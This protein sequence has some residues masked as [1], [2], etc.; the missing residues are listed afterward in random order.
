MLHEQ[1]KEQ[2][3][4]AG[5]STNHHRAEGVRGLAAVLCICK[6]RSAFAYRIHV[7]REHCLNKILNSYS[8]PLTPEQISEGIA[9]AQANALRLLDDARLLLE[10]GRLA[11]AAALA[12]L[13]MEERGKTIILKRLAIVRDPDDLKATWRDYRNH[14]A[15]NV[16]WIIPQLVNQGARTMLSMADSVD[17]NAEHAAVLDALK[18]V[19]FY[20]DCLGKRHWSVPTEVIDE[21][22]ARSMIKSAE[23]MWGSRSI[24][25]REL[26]L[27]RQIVGPQ[28]NQSGMAAAVVQWQHAMLEEGLCET[29][30]EKLAAFM[31]GMP[32]EVDNKTSAEPP[33]EE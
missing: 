28:Y 24:T 14:R 3:F 17:P 10:A 21:E 1:W 33:K 2:T 32:V 26:E 9:A 8:G 19:S 25:V 23:M 4:A 16:G 15:K 12:I 5:A 11:S 31:R 6:L 7:R 27:W 20:T 30:P 13:S 18:Q 22:L 29:E